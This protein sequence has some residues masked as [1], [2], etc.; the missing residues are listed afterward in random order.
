MQHGCLTTPGLSWMQFIL[1]M[2][3][4]DHIHYYTLQNVYTVLWNLMKISPPS[5]CFVSLQCWWCAISFLVSLLVSNSGVGAG[6][7]VT[8]TMTPK[9][10][11]INTDAKQ[12]QS[13]AVSSVQHPRP[14][15]THHL[16][17]CVRRGVVSAVG[18]RRSVRKDTCLCELSK[19]KKE[20]GSISNSR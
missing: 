1:V 13:N 11:R 7:P 5:G 12:P 10:R 2:H 17:Q 8:V 15:F 9:T 16:S 18:R 14:L 4:N 3:I 20:K 19:I 6:G